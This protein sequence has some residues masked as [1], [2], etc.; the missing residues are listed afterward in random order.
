MN[1]LF[2]V[3]SFL[4]L[5]YPH[6]SELSD[7]R[8]TKMVYLADWFSALASGH[9][10]TNINWYFNHYGPYVRDIYNF[11]AQSSEFEV[12]EEETPFGSSKTL[13]RYIGS[14]A[15]INLSPYA[16]QILNLVIEKTR[17]LYFNEFI[18]YVYSTYPIQAKERYAYLDLPTL[19]ATYKASRL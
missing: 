16:Q 3:M 6:S 18:S 11:A 14:P 10:L 2:D 12:L 9:Q 19:A 13:V 5:H 15:N 1:D 7:A 8:L 17:S 4:C